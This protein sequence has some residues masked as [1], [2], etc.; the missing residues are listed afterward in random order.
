MEALRVIDCGF[1]DGKLSE[2]LVWKVCT[3]R[4]VQVEVV[5]LEEI[6]AS[7]ISNWFAASR[8]WGLEDLAG[9]DSVGRHPGRLASH[10]N[11]STIC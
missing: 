1:F 4:C 9:C 6:M 3:L 2:M 10:D 7:N 8:Q 5:G 11:T